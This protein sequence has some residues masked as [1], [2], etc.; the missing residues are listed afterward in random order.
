MF[1]TATTFELVED[2]RWFELPSSFFLQTFTFSVFRITKMFILF[3]TSRIYEESAS[4]IKHLEQY[5]DRFEHMPS[6]MS[7]LKL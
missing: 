2:P 5:Q 4:V 7:I 6:S 3:Q 1:D